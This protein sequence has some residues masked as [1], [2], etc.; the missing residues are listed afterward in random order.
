MSVGDIV[1]DLQ[2]IA[3]FAN[4]DFQPV[5][6][7]EF[8]I[9]IVGS[10]IYAGITPNQAPDVG[11]RYYNGVIASDV[12]LIDLSPL[13]HRGLKLFIDNSIYLRIS[14]FA[15]GASNISFGGVQIK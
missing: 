8:M 4:L 5:A 14:S 12:A 3:G 6:G 2:N 13:L 7:T 15:V 11:I 1:N 10:S 9:T